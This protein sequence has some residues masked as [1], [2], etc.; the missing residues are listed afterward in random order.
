MSIQRRIAALEAR[1]HPG[2][3]IEAGIAYP[4]GMS[5]EHAEAMHKVV[6]LIRQDAIYD[7]LSL[8]KYS[9]D[10][11]LSGDDAKQHDAFVDK[12]VKDVAPQA[13]EMPA[14]ITLREIVSAFVSV[15]AKI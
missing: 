4:D 7:A 2:T 12:I 11:T 14:G 8:P 1:A 9:G 3:V 13:G 6:G 15:S 5:R 10:G